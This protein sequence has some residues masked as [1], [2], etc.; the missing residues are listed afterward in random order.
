VN[1]T[2]ST[3][4]GKGTKRNHNDDVALI[5]IIVWRTVESIREAERTNEDVFQLS[6][7]EAAAYRLPISNEAHNDSHTWA[8][9]VC[10][11][12]C[13][14]SLLSMDSDCLSN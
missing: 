10:L 14:L 3:S 8:L 9:S 11:S 1:Y 7:R 12:V 6:V 13:Q 4:E 5:T 2:V